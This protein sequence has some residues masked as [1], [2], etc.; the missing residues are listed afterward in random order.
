[1]RYGWLCLV[2]RIG[3]VRLCYY[4][5]FITFLTTFPNELLPM[6]SFPSLM[7]GFLAKCRVRLV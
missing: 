1:M 3:K 5:P 2:S 7:N 6:F 4:S